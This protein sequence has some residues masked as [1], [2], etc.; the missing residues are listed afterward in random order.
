MYLTGISTRTLSLLTKRLIGRS[1]SATEVSKAT[2]ELKQSI[3]TWRDRNLSR[4]KI[5]YLFIDGVIFRMRIRKGIE[6]VPILV[7]IGV[8]E[9]G[10]KLVLGLQAG[11][12]ESA[13]TWRQ[14]FKDLKTRGLDGASVTL[15][16]MDGLPGLEKVFEEEFPHAKIQRCQVHVAKNVIAK[17]PR[18][19][20]REVADDLRSIFYASS[21]KK[22]EELAEVFATKWEKDLPSAA[23]CLA[24]SLDACLT[25]FSFPEEEWISLRT[26][27]IIERLNKEFKRRTKPM[28][29]VAGENACYVLLAFISLKMELNWRN[30]KIG[31]VRP[32]L[33]LYKK[34][35]QLC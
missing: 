11:D 17:V 1:L 26:T 19:L 8:R 29:I 33:P 9:D 31:K 30:N 21:R 18:K 2:T 27:N 4:E 7:V 32:N 16:I 28:E 3:D 6:P 20:K 10:T 5:K 25:F 34:F 35:T 24:N 22:A 13:A 12:K 15:G 14:F 23:K